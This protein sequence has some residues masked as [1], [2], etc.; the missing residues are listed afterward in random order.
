MDE[1]D[2]LIKNGLIVDGT[3]SPMFKGSVA[4][5]GDKI[6]EVGEV[7]GDA[8]VVID[9]SG[10]VIS[11]GFIDVHTHADKTLPL[12]PKA[13][14]YVR[15]GITTTIG[16][17]CGNVAAPILDWWPPNMFWDMDIL[18]ELKPFK[19]YSEGLLPADEVKKKVKEVYGVDITWGLFKDFIKWL[20]DT[21]IS[22]NHVPLAGT[23]PLELK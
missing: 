7:K 15:Q 13:E 22:V 8:K 4:I 17:N 16:G 19:Y 12:F 10:L 11:P 3:G 20:E 18:F 1:Y 14:N 6:V 9:A 21:G 23:T 5:Q 2:I